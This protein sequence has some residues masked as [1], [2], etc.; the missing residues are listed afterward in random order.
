MAYINSYVETEVEVDIDVDDFY[1]SMSDSEK[2]HIIELL[3]V[4]KTIRCV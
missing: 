4:S 1:D 3:R 2:K